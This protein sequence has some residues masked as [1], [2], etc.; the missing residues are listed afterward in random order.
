MLTREQRY[1]LARTI[2]DAM[3]ASYEEHGEEGD[4][5]DAYRHLANDADDDELLAEAERWSE[6][7]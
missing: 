3:Q 6:Q 1:T 7:T 4:F 5:A 2:V